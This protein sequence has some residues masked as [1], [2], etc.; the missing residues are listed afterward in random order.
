M[1]KEQ[2][3]NKEEAATFVD[4]FLAKQWVQNTGC[5]L[6]ASLR[7]AQ[8]LAPSALAYYLIY[9]YDDKIVIGLGVASALYALASLA[10][11]AYTAEKN[12]KKR[13]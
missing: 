13:R 9:K 12:T 7:I 1:S 6:K 2:K 5:G 10:R 11:T 4:N 3:T 8:V